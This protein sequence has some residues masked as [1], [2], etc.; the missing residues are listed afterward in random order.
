M[1]RRILAVILALSSAPLFAAEGDEKTWDGT[2]TNRK[3]GTSGPLK[4]VA[5]EDG[6]GKWTATFSGKFKGDPFSYDVVF[7]S[8][9][10]KAQTD[11]TGTANVGG[12]EYEW[13]GFIKGNA[14]TG[15]FRAGNG[16][17]GQFI[18]REPAKKKR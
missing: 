16:N 4:C 10:G 1:S 18:L 2:W 7:Q 3:Y 6:D 8:K 5:T 9:A 17:N 15:R 14:L 11:L 13:Q 12:S